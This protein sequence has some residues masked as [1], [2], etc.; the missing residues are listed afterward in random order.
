MKHHALIEQIIMKARKR[1]RIRI[2]DQAIVSNHIHLQVKGKRRED[3]QN[4]FRVVAGHIAQAILQQFP[5]RK[6]EKPR[7][8][9]GAP[10]E[11]ES[12]KPRPKREKENKFWQTRIY[13]RVVSWG[14]DFRNVRNY[15]FQNFLEA[16]GLAPYKPRTR[17]WKSKNTSSDTS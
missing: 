1:F 17:S 7:E 8:W 10:G 14:E 11:H 13:T 16:M 5:I 2:Y 4:F 9:G 6:H 15:I 12:G 3:L